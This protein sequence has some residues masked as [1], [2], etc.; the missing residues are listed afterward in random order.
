[1]QLAFQITYFSKGKVR[2]KVPICKNAISQLD[3]S[4]NPWEVI[5]LPWKYLEIV[6]LC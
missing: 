6:Q 4:F 2:I 1:M 5:F 3:S